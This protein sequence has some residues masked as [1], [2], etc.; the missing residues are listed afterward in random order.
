MQ[1][2]DEEK[3]KLIEEVHAIVTVR[4]AKHTNFVAVS[5]VSFL[6]VK[7]LSLFFREQVKLV[8][9]LCSRACRDLKKSGFNVGQLRFPVFSKSLSQQLGSSMARCSHS[10]PAVLV[11]IFLSGPM[12]C[13]SSGVVVVPSSSWC[14][15]FRTVPQLQDRV[16]A[17]RWAV[18]LHL[19]GP[20]GQQPGVP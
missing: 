17:L 9:T 15:S 3:Q 14:I 4:D 12:H 11:Q 7:T 20:G 16:P 19:C 13:S 8:C 1:F 18:L 2:E 5:Q 10:S 6:G